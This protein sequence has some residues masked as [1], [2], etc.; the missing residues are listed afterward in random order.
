MIQDESKHDANPENN[1]Q[2]EE[3]MPDKEERAKASRSLLSSTKSVPQHLLDEYP[4]PDACTI[5]RTIHADN[6]LPLF[7]GRLPWGQF[8]DGKS[9]GL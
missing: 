5:S 7:Q 9:L 3:Q 4:I 6:F 1:E 2:N 8:Y